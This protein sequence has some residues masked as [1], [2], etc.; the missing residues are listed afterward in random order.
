MTTP[1]DQIASRRLVKGSEVGENA[2]LLKQ[3][4]GGNGAN[5]RLSLE[6]NLSGTTALARAPDPGCNVVWAG[7]PSRW[8]G[9]GP[10][11]FLL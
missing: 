3:G 6:E 5:V 4:W 8:V 9:I 7:G 10:P 2:A 11:Y 1:K